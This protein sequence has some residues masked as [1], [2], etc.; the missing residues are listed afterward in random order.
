MNKTAA[1][2]LI[3]VAILAG[4]AAAYAW[5]QPNISGINP[6]PTQETPEGNND[7]GQ[8][9]ETPATTTPS[10]G[11]SKVKIALLDLEHISNG[12]ER[13]CDKVVFVERSIATT[14]A[15]LNAALQQLFALPQERLGSWYNFI[16]R[17]NTTLT[18]DRAELVD[19]TAKIYLKGSL[20]GLSG[21]CD[22]PRASIQ[23][24]ETALQ[25]ATVK[26]VEL[27]LNSA[28]TTLIPSER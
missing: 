26:R 11:V 24:E 7:G 27:Y 25:F 9:N 15:P 4:G 10:T 16:A 18:F 17:T 6:F 23:I 14:T 1:T 8:E 3:L 20:S 5:L 13:G 22:D 21:V 12:K 28:P 2:I 19:D